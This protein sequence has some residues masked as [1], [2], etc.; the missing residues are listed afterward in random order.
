M[1]KQM[2]N[3]LGVFIAALVCFSPV[4]ALAAEPDTP[5]SITSGFDL[6]CE[7]AECTF[8]DARIVYGEAEPDTWITFQVSVPD[9]NGEPEEI[10][11]EQFSVGS[12]GLFSATLPLEMGHNYVT[13]TAVLDGLNETTVEVAIKRVPQKVKKQLQ[14]MIALPGVTA[15][16]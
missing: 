8:D 2:K 3:L 16:P 10:F 14:R 6:E 9:Q 5:V 15:E 13:M 7:E 12:L 1:K 4:S 11:S